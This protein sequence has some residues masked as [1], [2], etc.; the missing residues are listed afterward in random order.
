MGLKER[1]EEIEQLSCV[2]LDMSNFKK[3]WVKPLR[4]GQ[5]SHQVQD[6]LHQLPNV[7]KTK[8]HSSLKD[9]YSEFSELSEH[10]VIQDRLHAL[11]SALVEMKLL[12]SRG[13]TE[14]GKMSFLKGK[15][16][17]D[18]QAGISSLISQVKTFD[19]KLQNIENMYHDINGYLHQSLSLEHSV[20][21]LELPHYTYLK[22]L[23]LT[24]NK[25]K[26]LLIN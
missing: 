3:H 22:N 23:Q 6:E 21:L 13:A 24:N 2:N 5:K 20:A 11:S 17:Q 4:K 10:V 7:Q 9:F 12:S 16:L 1:R 8:L 15:V 18:Q 14:S 26:K 19:N 25:Q